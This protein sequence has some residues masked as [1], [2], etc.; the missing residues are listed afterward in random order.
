VGGCGGW[1]EFDGGGAA[2]APEDAAMLGFSLCAFADSGPRLR[3]G[4]FAALARCAATVVRLAQVLEQKR[5]V[6][7]RDWSAK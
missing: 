1:R 6:R 4:F 2:L 3:Y 7:L 5:R